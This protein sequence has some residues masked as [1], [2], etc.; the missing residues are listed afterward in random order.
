MMFAM[1]LLWG[2]LLALGVWGVTNLFPGRRR[3]S[4]LDEEEL[5]AREVL[6]RRYARGEITRQVYESMKRDIG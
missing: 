2:V 5:S 4:G 6:A 3:S 1:V